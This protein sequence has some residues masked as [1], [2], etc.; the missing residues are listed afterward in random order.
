V[1]EIPDYLLAGY[2]S[3]EGYM[4]TPGPICCGVC[5]QMIPSDTPWYWSK[6]KFRWDHSTVENPCID[7]YAQIFSELRDGKTAL[8]FEREYALNSR[9]T[10]EELRKVD[11]VVTPCDCE[12]RPGPHWQIIPRYLLEDYKTWGRVPEDWTWPPPDQ[13]GLGLAKAIH[14]K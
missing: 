4:V 14:H 10:V 11:R 3:D 7:A 8:Q 12:D 2:E 6:E 13:S 9:I 5:H 1:T